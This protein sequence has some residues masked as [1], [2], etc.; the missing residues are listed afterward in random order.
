M[1]V[2]TERPMSAADVLASVTA[3]APSIAACAPEIEKAR[4]LTADLLD[5]LKAAGT[6]RLSLPP[7][8][9]GLGAEVL[10]VLEA[11]AAADGSTGWTAMI[12]AGGWIDLAGL[13]RATFDAFFDGSDI[14]TAGVIAPTGSLDQVGSGYRVQG[15]GRSS[16][17]VNTPMSST[18]TASRASPTVSRSCASRCSG[19]RTC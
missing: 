4:R 11:L 5:D 19:R 14:V 8:H 16:V 13:P 6:F 2:I 15:G 7:S 1:S 18:S 9:G 3:V 17:V 10:D 12:G